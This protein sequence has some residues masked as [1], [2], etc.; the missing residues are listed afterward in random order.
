[1]KLKLTGFALL[2]VLGTLTGITYQSAKAQVRPIQSIRLI[3]SP[4]YHL[5]HTSNYV[6]R[7]DSKTGLTQRLVTSSDGGTGKN[8]KYEWA[9]LLDQQVGPAGDAGRYEVSDGSGGTEILVRIDT[10]TGKTWVAVQTN[11]LNWQEVTPK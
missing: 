11:I 5:V 10:S 6:Y 2:A 4:D 8:V 3:S 9:Q 1:M 7:F